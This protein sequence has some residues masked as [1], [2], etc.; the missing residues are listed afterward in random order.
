MTKWVYTFGDGAA[1]GRAGDRNLLGGKGA[2]LAEMCSLG[3]PVPPGFTITTEV[4]SAY[5]ANECCY[6][7]S[8]E[9]D[10]AVALD[11][12]GRLTG[13]RF[14]DPS[15]LLLVSV[16]SGARAS[17]PGMMDTVLNLG[18]NDETVE[19]LAADSGDAR[20][21]YDSYRRFI[22]MYSDVVMGLD[23][24]VFE[25]I[26]EDQKGGLGH[27][28]DTELTAIEWQGV[29]ALYKAKV[30]EELGKPFP[31]D[32]NEQLWGA[33]GAVFSSWMNSRAI[34]YR[35][36]HDIPES[37]GTAVNVQAMVFG[38]MGETSATG[39]AFTRNPSTGEKMLYGEFLVNAQGE[40]VVAG[41]RTPQNI[42]E[43]ARIAAG[44]DKPSLQKLMPDA[45]QS[46][47]T[48]SDRLEK[49]Y[50]DMQDLE[51][52]IERGKL[53]MLQTRSG[54]RTAKAA[55]RIAVEMAQDKLISKEEAVAR[56]DPASLD[57]LLHPTIDPEAAR[58]VI[59]IGLPASPGAA[60]GEIV[61][62]SND[63]EELKTQGRKA[64]LVR[65]E[66]SPEDIHG[67]HAAEGIL[68][69]RGGMTSHAAVVA[70]GMGK[71]CVSGAGSLRVDYRA[72]TLTAMGSTL[73][74]G[75]IITIDG[76]NGQVLKGAV[77]MLQP[78]LSGD[79]A[80][81]MEWADGVR[82]MKVRTNAETPLDARMARSFGAEGI[83]LCR[84]EHMFF[85]G[86]R[87]VAMREMILAETEKGRRTALAK[88]LPM[89]RSDFLELF[90]IMAGLPVTIR[91][92]DPPL[93]EFLP[94]TEEEVAE[95]AAAMNVSPDKLRQRTE[96]LH[97]F[98][99][100]L[101][102][103]GCRLAVS[104]PEIAEMQARAI[105]EAAVE[106]GRKAG[107]L[108]VPEIMVP[109]VGL[110]K[111]LDYV[112]ARIDAV[113]KSVMEET[114]VKITYLTGTMIE[115]PRAAIR[116]HVIAEAAE[117]FSFGTNDLTQT[118]FGIS[119]DD[120]ASFLETYRQKGIIEQDPFVSLDIEGVGELVRMAAE[121]G[122]ATRPDIKLGICGEH[123]GDPA[124]IH[125]CEEVGLDYVSCS[126]YRVPIA[127]L[128]AA[129]AA[130][131][132]SKTSAPRA[133]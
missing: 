94:K 103:R 15:K 32:P 119:R 78:E 20:F 77:P 127:R 45:F 39:V 79:F 111:E 75:D 54:K 57:Q 105:F 95:V 50:R 37:W 76:G 96:A 28:L 14:G 120:A 41:I 66:T 30:E 93:H 92:L 86:D 62:S 112:K 3:L 27:E 12:I 102:H 33:I 61:F 98:N 58:D 97:E 63:A 89:Q 67:M 100:M 104:Y 51:F 17:M 65:I 123:G 80:A 71:P 22:Q 85:D 106:A 35:R 81:I 82:R 24:E 11:H 46:F 5:Y 48:I 25:E 18:L 84:T 9:A 124:S 19:A 2:N 130:V 53:W 116:A 1:E 69:T 91:L 88:L 42:T 118:T 117:F 26:L 34:T 8:L 74:K 23:H 90:E 109:L 126:P 52:T 16:R 21:A 47:V 40:D 101:G 7:A 83:G 87:I 13:R 73:R 49:H 108:V 128:A 6:P 29:I 114:G 99:P 64:I 31:Q 60:T 131:Q 70:R 36:L 44:S 68:T 38:N 107:A 122:R 10:V 59:G 72:G 55:L 132:V 115:L 121:K 56:I 129:Q 133:V 4:C 125:F 43:A 113:A 110:V